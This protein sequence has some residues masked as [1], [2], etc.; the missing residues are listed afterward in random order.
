V[1]ELLVAPAWSETVPV[2][3]TGFAVEPCTESVCAAL[4]WDGTVK[5]LSLSGIAGEDPVLRSWPVVVAS[6]EMG[7]G[8]STGGGGS[9]DPRFFLARRW[10]EEG[11]GWTGR[12]GPWPPLW[13]GERRSGRVFAIHLPRAEEEEEGMGV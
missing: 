10:E 2:A 3:S 8:G 6:P 7:A 5:L 1:R 4:Q 9:D 11:V 12:R 13:C